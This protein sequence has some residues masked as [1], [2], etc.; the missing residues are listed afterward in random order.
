MVISVQKPELSDDAL[1]LQQMEEGSKQAFNSLFEKYW[2]R[3]FSDAYKR[4]KD[5][6]AAKDVVQDIFT[7]IWINRETL[8]I[9]SLPAY[10]HT[11]VRNRAIKLL[12]RQEKSHPFFAILETIP[13][14]NLQADASLLRKEFLKAYESFVETLPPRR[15]LIFR[16][17]VYDDLYTKDIAAQLGLSRKTVQNQ[18]IKAAKQLRVSLS[19]M[20]YC[21]I[22]FLQTAG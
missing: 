8:H 13:E 22:V 16:L 6:D 18:L 12:A 7:H 17:R 20:L 9:N 3:A 5:S 21:L 4:L 1:L 11:A 2:D 14:K 15:Q 19:H 10:L